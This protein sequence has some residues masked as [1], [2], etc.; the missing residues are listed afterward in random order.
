MACVL[1]EYCDGPREGVEHGHRCGEVT[2]HMLS[3]RLHAEFALKTQRFRLR[4]G[5]HSIPHRTS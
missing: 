3:S 4:R 2:H 5:Q 1:T